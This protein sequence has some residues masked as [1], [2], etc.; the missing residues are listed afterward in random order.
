MRKMFFA[1]VVLVLLTSG[2]GTLADGLW[3]EWTQM[4]PPTSPCARTGGG[5]AYDSESDRLIIFGGYS[6]DW[7][8]RD[9]TWAYDYDTDTWEERAPADHPIGRGY[10]GQAYDAESDRVIL[11][12]GWSGYYH[13]LDTWA[14]EYDTNTWAQMSPPDSP[15]AR[16]YPS[17]VYD[18]KSDRVILFGGDNIT[19][20]FDDTWAYDYNNNTWQQKNPA[21]WPSGR[22]GAGTAYDA[23]S[24]RI[25]LFGGLNL[26]SGERFDDTW[27]YD[28]ER[29][30]WQQLSPAHHPTARAVYGN[31]YYDADID[32]VILFG[33][34]DY[35]GGLDDTW[36]YDYNTNTWEELSPVSRPS[37]RAGQFGAYDSQSD[38]VVIFGGGGPSGLLADTWVFRMGEFPAPRDWLWPGWNWISIPGV[39]DDPNP[40]TLFGF[41][42][43]R[44]LW[45]WDRYSK[46]AQ[47]YRPPFVTFNLGVGDSYLLWLDEMPEPVSYE[48]AFA[49]RPFEFKLG[50]AGWTWIGMPRTDELGY[51]QFMEKAC[52][53]YPVGGFVRTAAEDYAWTPKNWLQWCWFFW[54]GELQAPRPFAPYLPFGHNTCYPWVGYRCWVNVGSALDE[55]DPDQVTLIWP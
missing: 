37:P 4:D 11:F 47:V 2:S 14:C 33:G 50:R 54:D 48:G 10:T 52:V 30:T 32:R 12:G 3:G 5:T 28:Y 20:S 8:W 24:D 22:H 13:F 44:R 46:S 18:S 40:D 36:A 41:D 38:R 45:Y 43:S 34:E 55:N 7:T 31:M 1:V 53:Q 19:T 9:D 29:D 25:I 39:P 16:A 6:G 15:A 49:E 51:V 35:S 17:L 42:C 26:Q 21:S 27:A 23:E